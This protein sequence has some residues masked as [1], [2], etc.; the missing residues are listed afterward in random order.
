MRRS[1]ELVLTVYWLRMIEPSAAADLHSDP[2]LALRYSVPQILTCRQLIVVTTKDWNDVNASVR[3]LERAGTGHTPWREVGNPVPG[4]I[5]RRGFAWGVGLHGTGETGAPRKK[6][7]DQRSPAGV[8][9]LYTVFGMA[10]PDRIGF[11]R[12]PY[13]QVTSTTQAIDDPHSRYYNRIVDR[14]AIKHPDWSSSESMLR[15]GGRYRFGVMIEHNWSKIPG[16][17]SC[18]FLHVWGHERGGTAGCTAMSSA[19]L[20]HLLYRLDTEKNPLIV[21][22]PLPEY[23]RLKQAW[24]LPVISPQ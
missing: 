11:L 10:S 18:I 24:D 17:G 8:F 9:R 16:F 15:V 19:A 12:F 6:E 4:V 5:G 14:A 1:A 21:Q 20:M 22:L 13:E 23:D 3:V 2:P 7:G